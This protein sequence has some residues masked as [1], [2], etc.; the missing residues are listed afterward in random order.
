MRVSPDRPFAYADDIGAAIRAVDWSATP[1]GPI[2]AWPQSLRAIVD[3]VLASPLPLIV[4]WGPDLIQIYN[5]G[6]ATIAGHRHPFALGQ[7][8]RECWPEV[9]DFNEPMYA[10]VLRGET[11]SFGD[12]LLRL[13]RAGVLEDHWFDLTYSAVRD[14]G[15][16]IAGALVSVVDTTRRMIAERQIADQVARKRRLFEQAPGFICILLGPEHVYEFGNEAYARLSGRSDFVGKTV[17]EAFPDLMGQGFFE[18]LDHVYRTGE[19]FV[20]EEVPISM[21]RTPDG[22]P[23]ERFIDFIYEPTVDESGGVTGIFVQGH[24]VTDAHL[25]RTAL[26]ETEARLTELNI[27][28]ERQVAER[29]RELSRTWK[30]S[31]DLMGI[32]DSDGY[33]GQCN[34]AFHTVLGWSA[35]DMREHRVFDLIHPE[36]I[37]PSLA[38]FARLK[39]GESIIAFENRY[40][41]KAGYW[42]ALSWVAAPEGD[43]Y[44]CSARDITD[45]KARA[46]AMQIVE[47]QLRQSQK[48]EAVGHLT[49]GIAHDFNNML[50]GML[51]AMT[52]VQRRVAAGRIDDIDRFI[53]GARH[54]GERA[55]ALISRL[56]AFSRQ[57][58]LKIETV[59]INTL[60]SGMADLL[61][62]TIGVEISLSLALAPEV[63]AIE[64]DA[65]QLE[66][67]LLN[68]AINAR[69]AMPDGGALTISAGNVM[70]GGDDPAWPHDLPAG[71]YVAIAVTDTGTG[72]ARDV[73]ERA[74]DP[75]FTTKPIGKGTG[76][77]LSMIYGFARQSHGHAVIASEVGTGTTITLYLPRGLAAV[78]PPQDRGVAVPTQAA[79]G[80][81]VLVVDDEAAV[82]IVIAD[83]LAEM[84]YSVLE[85]EDAAAALDILRSDRDIDLMITDIGMSGMTGRQLAELARQLRPRLNVLFVTGYG[86]TG[87]SADFEQP[88]EF[89][90]LAKPFAIDA[91]TSHVLRLTA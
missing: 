53:D 91:L 76:L 88:N 4:L 71:G 30:V 36:D 60:A 3:L 56:M 89:A 46:S 73:I 12:Q 15:G 2:D 9:W 17:R 45:E 70:I 54:S 24:D 44:Y 47:A 86:G 40:R 6:Y 72:M 39:A 67:A 59:D 83:V 31:P 19:R 26:R 69:D 58:P 27:D 29:A 22:R 11:R 77:G 43:R 10:A 32:L 14:D 33:L 48:M 68:L 28:L 7:P 42:R 38:A 5:D 79:A 37:A 8:T 55:A 87:M 82:R 57:Q 62:R 34:P 78:R 64:A 81:T 84:E 20:A 75:F 13:E 49:S 66:S 65:A 63:W 90:V 41:T 23:E 35:D 50:A 80:K 61:R 16:A 85:S 74:F 18:K 25:A 51:G 1:I 21:V 52:I